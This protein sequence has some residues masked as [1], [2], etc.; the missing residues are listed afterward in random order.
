MTYKS[1]YFFMKQMKQLP[2][3]IPNIALY[4][5]ASCCCPP[6]YVYFQR[7]AWAQKKTQQV[8]ES[9]WIWLN[10][11]IQFWIAGRLQALKIRSSKGFFDMP[12]AAM[13]PCMIYLCTY[14][15]LISWYIKVIPNIDP[16]TYNY[17]WLSHGKHTKTSKQTKDMSSKILQLD[18][19]KV[20]F[21]P[22]CFFFPDFFPWK[23]YRVSSVP[24][25]LALPFETAKHPLKMKECHLK[26]GTILKRNESSAKPSFL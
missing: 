15:S 2:T 5:A 7:R 21:F 23:F 8:F 1:L 20:G 6:F 17:T 14:I 16:I 25:T 22:F 10:G 13:G 18:L 9:D 12:M 3:H 19:A 24:A 26:K 4:Q 11:W